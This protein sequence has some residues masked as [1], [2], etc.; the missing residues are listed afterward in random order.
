M[1]KYQPEKELKPI[2]QWTTKEWETA[3]NLL[4]SKFDKLKNKMRIALNQLSEAQK[5][6]S[7]AVI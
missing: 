1:G 5:H 7:E 4:N 6:L 3:Y 2:E